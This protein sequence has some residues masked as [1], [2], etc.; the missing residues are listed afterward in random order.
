M[1]ASTSIAEAEFD[2]TYEGKRI[3]S[4]RGRPLKGKDGSFIVTIYHGNTKPPRRAFF[5]FADD[6]MTP[7]EIIGDEARHYI[8]VPLMR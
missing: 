2:Q 4:C 3:S 7:Q 1:S 8:D 5:R 6:S